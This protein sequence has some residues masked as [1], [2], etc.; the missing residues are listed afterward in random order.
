MVARLF[1]QPTVTTLALAPIMVPLPPKQA[2]RARD[3]QSTPDSAPG[4]VWF[5]KA[6]MGS[7]VAVK[8]MLSMKAEAMALTHR[9]MI[10]AVVRLPPERSFTQLAIIWIRPVSSAP[11]MTMNRPMKKTRVGHSTSCLQ[12]LD[13][14]LPG[15]GQQ[16]QGAQQGG[17]GDRHVQEPVE[18]KAGW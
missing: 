16:H 13:D 2:P 9:T 7:M 14:V 12:H 3:H 11:A 1:R 4:M 10:M 17:D 6:M 15:D 18:P 5:R 8:G